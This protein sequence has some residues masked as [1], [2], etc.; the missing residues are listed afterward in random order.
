MRS[1]RLVPWMIPFLLFATATLA[2]PQEPAPS[3]PPPGGAASDGP[4]IEME[5]VVV[6][7]VQPGPGL[8]KVRHGDHILYVL[9]T[10]SPL[11]KNITW[12]SDE[13]TLALQH[14][15]EVLGSPGI[16]VDA[17]VGFFRGLTMVPSAM[18]AMK[19]P[20]GEKLQ[21]VLPP[22]L[23]AR[24]SMLK[25]QYMG[26]DGGI[27][28]KRPLIAVFQLY[29][30]AL[31]RSGMKETGVIDPVIN[32]V[33]KAR[34][35]KRTPTVLKVDIDDPRAALAD[36]R[37]ETLKGED[38]AC[39]RT[40]LDVIE[41][42]LPQVAA[43][44][45]AW[46]VGDW[47]ALRSSAREDQRLACLSAWFNTETARKRGLTDLEQRMRAT[48]LETAEGALRRNR[49]TFATLPVSQLVKADGYL[50]HLQAK[51]YAVEAPE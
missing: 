45:N 48:W 3:D 23:Y 47:A 22:D 10:Q 8:W 14:A 33:L 39:F 7:G 9:G 6:S 15:D 40:T 51:G 46:A 31:S 30:E 36:F 50:A 35:M 44:A 19:N 11:P 43:R 18:K 38:L 4:V 13:V 20:D 5:A 27:E 17:D 28:K 12:R 1:Y 32:E 42:D 26:R 2:Q 24:W 29:Q 37:K 16:T 25:R 41:N 21:D 34:K 49:I